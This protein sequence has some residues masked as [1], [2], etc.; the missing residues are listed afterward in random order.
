MVEQELPGDEP[1]VE[2]SGPGGL[3]LDPKTLVEGDVTEDDV[4]K[5]FQALEGA[6]GKPLMADAFPA[7]AVSFA[8]YC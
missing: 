8:R 7:I 1:A 5:T 2:A 3:Y 4:L 6:D